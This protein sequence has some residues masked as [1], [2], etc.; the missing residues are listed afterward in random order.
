MSSVHDAV[1]VPPPE[2]V[3]APNV[4]ASAATV[5]APMPEAVARFRDALAAERE[6]LRHADVDALVAIQDEKRAALDGLREAGLPQ[7]I[8][9]AFARE[10]QANL[11][12][13]HHLVSCLR[14]IVV[15]DGGAV[16]GKQGHVE[17]TADLGRRHG[18]A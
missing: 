6:A 5:P 11:E 4:A 15:S 8:R 16:Y 3:P 10:A 12:L 1:T 13:M 7:E 17:V 14:G 9:D 18:A 2:T